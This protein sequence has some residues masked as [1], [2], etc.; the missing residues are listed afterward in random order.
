MSS[1]Y[2]AYLY[3]ATLAEGQI[4]IL[5]AILTESGLA[6]D[7]LGKSDPPSKWTGNADQMAKTILRGES[8][9]NWTWGL[10]PRHT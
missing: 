9:T 10:S 5:S 2:V 7:R 6:I 3:T 8:S 1:M 4:E